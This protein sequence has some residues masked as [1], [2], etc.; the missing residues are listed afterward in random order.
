MSERYTLLS[1]T[2][3]I[4]VLITLLMFTLWYDA[5]AQSNDKAKK[6]K[7]RSEN[8]KEMGLKDFYENYFPIGVAVS[9]RSL[10]GDEAELIRKHF[11][12]LT[13]ENVM[14]MGP[15][16]PEEDRYNWEPADRIVDF[17]Q[18]NKMRMRGHTLCW[19]NQAPPWMFKDAAGDTVSKEVLLKRLKDHI[20]EVVTRYKGKIYAWDV[21]NEVIDDND[22]RHYRQSQW[23]KICGEEF[24][25]RA[26]EWAHAADPDAKLFYNDYNTESPA[27]REKIYQ[28][29][30]K[31][32]DA[33]VPIHGVGLQAHWHLDDPTEL[34]LRN[35]I[36]KFSS[37]GL[38]IQI[39]ELDVSVYPGES[40][41]REKRPD[42]TGEFTPEMEQ[43]Q[44][45]LYKMVFE[46]FRDQSDK[47]TS[48]TFW[49]VS[50]R[51]SW[52][53][54]FPVRGRKNHPL[55]FDAN[56][57]PKKAYWEIVNFEP[58]K[59]KKPKKKRSTEGVNP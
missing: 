47:I 49:N 48:V 1:S 12:S 3:I 38:E 15:I 5:H 52:L 7:Q 35:S 44:M 58:E 25:A 20:T 30:K 18:Q 28:M 51:Y 55:L 8:E 37:L 59:K 23:Y 31:L 57:K 53:D 2:K 10:S 24:I 43:K 4:S 46:V 41:R 27:K 14:K 6:E 39:T 13:A 40:G 19:H 21:V 54:N 50:D 9:P 42:E 22:A 36:E 11:N 26:F 16:H 17:A 33:K 45:A 34:E 56:L 29:L 32:I